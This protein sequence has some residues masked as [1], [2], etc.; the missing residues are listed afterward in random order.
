MLG[1]QASGNNVFSSGEI[2]PNFELELPLLSPCL[3][4]RAKFGA[5]S[6]KGYILTNVFL[7]NPNAYH[8]TWWAWNLKIIQALNG[9][10]MMSNVID[11]YFLLS[12]FAKTIMSI[13]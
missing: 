13:T 9:T 11:T 1:N 2:L 8:C 10:I 12:S 5:K 4:I 7:L 3:K 6:S